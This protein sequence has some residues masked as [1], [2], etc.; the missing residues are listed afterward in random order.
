MTPLQICLN[1]LDSLGICYSYIIDTAA[2]VAHL[3]VNM[4]AQTVVLKSDAQYLLVVVP[5]ESL[6]EIGKVLSVIGTSTLRFA[7]EAERSVLF[8]F[9]TVDWVPP[10]GGLVGAPVY[11][12]SELADQESLTFNA[13]NRRDLIHMKTADFQ[14]IGPTVIGSFCEADYQKEFRYRLLAKVKGATA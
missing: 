7:T 1:Y 4:V 3:S 11:L 10:L 13:S 5:A 12:D 8:P 14:R 9:G 2:S 6:V